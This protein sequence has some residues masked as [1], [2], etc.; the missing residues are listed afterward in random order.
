VPEANASFFA[1]YARPRTVTRLRVD[2]GWDMQ[3]PDR[4]E[5]FWPQEVLM[6]PTNVDKAKHPKGI[7]PRFTK[8]GGRGPQVP[9][10]TA[11]KRL[12]NRGFFTFRYHG[13]PGLREWDQLYLYQEIAAKRA[14][15][16][17][18]IPYRQVFPTIASHASG[19]SDLN[20]GGKALWLDCELLQLGFL[21][22]TYIP[23]ASPMKG[24]GT[25]HT[26]LEPSLM[27]SLRLAQETYLQ[28]Q[29]SEWIP[30]GGSPGYQGS[31]FITHFSLNQVLFRPYPSSPLIGTLE[32]NSWSFQA[33][34]YTDPIVGPFQKASGDTYASLGPG[35]RQSVCNNLDF[36]GALAFPISDHHWASTQL[37]I[38]LRILY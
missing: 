3:F 20:L 10:Q 14:S 7:P 32:F 22:R 26:T 19:F 18:E 30:L 28:G 6:F 21:F 23:T 34:S 1:D 33:G 25:G 27:A 35:L 11:T 16:F 8:D 15:F 12:H 17:I 9:P 31:M 5:Y 38:E 36:G 37:R 13:E 4:A 24:L 2:L 29:I